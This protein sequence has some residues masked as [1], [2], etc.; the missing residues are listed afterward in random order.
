[1]KIERTDKEII[2]R[3]PASVDTEGLQ[4]LVDY[5]RYKEITSKFEVDQNDV[6][7]LADEINESW[8]S[9]NKDRFLK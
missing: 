6:D 2:I 3:I 7:K 4:E 9:K 5:V 1:M 8:W